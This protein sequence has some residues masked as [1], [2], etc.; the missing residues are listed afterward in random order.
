VLFTSTSGRGHIQPL[1]PLIRAFEIAPSGLQKTL[2]EANFNFRLGQEPP[3]AESERVW[4]VFPTLARPEASRLVEREW[5]AGLC[6]NALLPAMESAFEEW[7]PEL[8]IRESCEYSAGFVADRL[9]IRHAQVGISTAAAETS[10]LTELVEPALATL[11]PN[12][13]RRILATPY[14]TRFPASLDPSPFPTT[15]RYTDRSRGTP[16]RLPDWW[17]ASRL[18]LVYV[19]LGTVATGVEKG[20]ELLRCVVETLQELDIRILA[21]TG[22]GVEPGSLNDFDKNVHVETWVNQDDVFDETSLVVCHGGSGTTFGALAAG[23]PLVLLPMFA[24]QPTNARLVQDVGAGISITEG[25][26]SA[27]SNTNTIQQ[28]MAETREALLEVLANS[29]YRD[30]ALVV[31]EEINGSDTPKELVSRL[32]AT[33][34]SVFKSTH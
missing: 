13:G 9:G 20:V 1:I 12:L 7:S 18:P 30:S 23:V 3:R 25:D 29:T 10:V 24:D 5:F 8:V 34:H 4:R 33:D 31:A 11:S 28:R 27:S 14:L 15:L 21:A 17:N 2:E 16:R 26:R 19:T 32:I 22:Y 6:L